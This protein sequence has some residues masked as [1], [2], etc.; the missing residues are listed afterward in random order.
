MQGFLM[1][2]VVCYAYYW[3]LF[4]LQLSMPQKGF[5][6]RIKLVDKPKTRSVHRQ[7]VSKITTY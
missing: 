5:D 3:M 2:V 4:P 1:I 7:V 6:G